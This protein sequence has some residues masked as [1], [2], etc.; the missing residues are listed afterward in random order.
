MASTRFRDRTVTFALGATIALVVAACSPQATTITAEATPSE[1]GVD[2]EDDP[3]P[4]PERPSTTTADQL[5][6]VRAGCEALHS[7]FHNFQ[8]PTFGTQEDAERPTD[9][10]C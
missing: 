4:A 8:E 2:I 1:R 3:G 9:R 7:F 6:G 5:I 10:A